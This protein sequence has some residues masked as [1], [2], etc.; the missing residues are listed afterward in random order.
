MTTQMSADT[1]D[2]VT[3]HHVD[4]ATADPDEG[5][6]VE[7]I[8][9]HRGQRGRRISW[10]RVLVY[11]VLPILTLLLTAGAGYAKWMYGSAQ[12]SSAARTES[13]QAAKDS[14]VAMLSYKPDTVE[15]DLTKAR[16]HLTGNL[17]DS[18]ASLIHDVVIPGSRAKQISTAA[19]VAAAASVSASENHAFVLVFVNQTITIGN[20]APTNTASSVRMTLDKRDGRW[21]VSQFDPV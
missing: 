14:A 19:T 3:D 21:L 15:Q 7:V 9:V 17:K 5:D 12:A 4:A 1:A 18:Y 20:S 11:G 10:R 16:D 8:R 13:M 6:A 2:A